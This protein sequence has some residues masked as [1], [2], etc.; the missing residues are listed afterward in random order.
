MK[1]LF[2]DIVPKIADF[3]VEAGVLAGNL[4]TLL[5]PAIDDLLARMA[6]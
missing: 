4:M 1:D 3:A 2:F 5:K 6:L